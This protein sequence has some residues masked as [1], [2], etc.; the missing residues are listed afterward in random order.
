[1]LLARRQRLVQ[2]A[3]VAI[4]LLA[5]FATEH[6]TWTIPVLI[7]AAL[8]GGFS[9]RRTL[10][11]ETWTLGD[12]L[13]YVVAITVGGAGFWIVLA[14]APGLIV[15]LINDWAPTNDLLSAMVLGVVF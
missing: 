4:S 12:Y 7:L 9:F 5:V 14:F 1:M 6:A 8:I 13:P 15:A 2:V 10:Y 3:A 11:G